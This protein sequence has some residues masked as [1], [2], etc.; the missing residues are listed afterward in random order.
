MH[1]LYSKPSE[2]YGTVRTSVKSV[3]IGSRM[4]HDQTSIMSMLLQFDK[5]C[6]Y[7]IA[8]SFLGDLFFFLL[9]RPKREESLMLSQSSLMR[10]K[11]AS[12]LCLA[13]STFGHRAN[14][15]HSSFTPGLHAD[16]VQLVEGAFSVGL[17]LYCLIWAAKLPLSELTSLAGSF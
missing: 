2:A 5:N 13:C 6:I 14:S 10:G 12:I 1:A 7:H 16:I 9:C 4:S 11:E 17:R 15:W 3:I 8:F